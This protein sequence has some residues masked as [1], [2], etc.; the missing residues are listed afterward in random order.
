M[1]GPLAH[2][3]PD[4]K[5]EDERQKAGVNNVW[6]CKVSSIL[7]A[8]AWSNHDN[9]PGASDGDGIWSNASSFKSAY[10]CA[11][12]LYAGK[13]PT[14]EQWKDYLLIGHEFSHCVVPAQ[15]PGGYFICIEGGPVVNWKSAQW[16]YEHPNNWTA[17]PHAFFTGC[18][19]NAFT[20]VLRWHETPAEVD[21]AYRQWLL[22][23]GTERG[24]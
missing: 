20:R 7:K 9:S 1:S 15:D 5:F 6:Y 16:R 10:E 11:K 3:I 13:D 24:L 23:V 17:I 8:G 4:D 12:L 19:V 22:A 18:K 2:I 21:K 14:P